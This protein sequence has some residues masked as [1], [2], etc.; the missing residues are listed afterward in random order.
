MCLRNNMEIAR[1]REKLFSSYFHENNFIFGFASFFEIHPLA[2]LTVFVA[3]VAIDNIARLHGEIKRDW[4]RARDFWRGLKPGLIAYLGGL[5]LGVI[6]NLSVWSITG[7]MEE[8]VPF[9]LPSTLFGTVLKFGIFIPFLEEVTF[10]GF[11]QEKI[12]LVQ[13]WIFKDKYQTLQK[14]SRIALQSL[15][16]GSLHYFYYSS[17]AANMIKIIACVGLGA[18]AGYLKEKT[19]SLWPSFFFHAATN[20]LSM[21]ALFMPD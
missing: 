7:E 9:T 15:I 8:P 2:S 3:D 18:I 12:G 5:L 16:F 10:R 17:L 19:D 13:K 21:V 14:V 1:Q 20:S 6:K 11:L 4:F